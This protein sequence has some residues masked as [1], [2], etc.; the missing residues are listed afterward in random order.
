MSLM[1]SVT[2]R[3]YVLEKLIVSFGASVLNL[4]PWRLRGTFTQ[5]RSGKVGDVELDIGS[6][7]YASIGV[8]GTVQ[9]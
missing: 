2:Q 5:R 3:F 1:L 4:R 9:Y 6:V 8:D 7:D